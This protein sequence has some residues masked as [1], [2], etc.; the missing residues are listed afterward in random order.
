M[1]AQ[2][3]PT[4]QNRKSLRTFF[5]SAGYKNGKFWISPSM[6]SCQE[7]TEAEVLKALTSFEADT[8][9]KPVDNTFRL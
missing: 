5:K 4:K 1:N 9:K 2:I 6:R 7:E 8:A 3:T